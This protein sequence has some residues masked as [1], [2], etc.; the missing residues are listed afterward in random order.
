MT[1]FTKLY[2]TIIIIYTF[3]IYNLEKELEYKQYEEPLSKEYLLAQSIV[4]ACFGN[5]TQQV[6]YRTDG[7]LCITEQDR[8]IAH[9]TGS[10]LLY[11]EV[12]P[13]G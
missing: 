5:A 4:H 9:D 10:S 7:H 2:Y 6:G 8:I 11:G 1:S 13:R 3:L 12:L